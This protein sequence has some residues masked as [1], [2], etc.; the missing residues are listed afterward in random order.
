MTPS[1]ETL[2]SPGFHSCDLLD[3]A[4]VNVADEMTVASAVAAEK[5]RLRQL[6]SFLEKVGLGRKENSFAW[7]KVCYSQ[8]GYG[9]PSGKESTS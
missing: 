3:A 6:S 5:A 2:S 4:D 9:I 1:S 7:T 8:R